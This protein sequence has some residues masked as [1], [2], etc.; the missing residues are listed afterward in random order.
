MPIFIKKIY[1][2]AIVRFAFLYLFL[3]AL[4]Y[5]FREFFYWLE[6]TGFDWRSQVESL[7]TFIGL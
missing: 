7:K 4:L 2:Q 6:L 5:L 1:R 3:G